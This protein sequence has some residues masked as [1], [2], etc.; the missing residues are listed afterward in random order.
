MKKRDKPMQR[1]QVKA[2]QADDAHRAHKEQ[3]NVWLQ[4]WHCLKL[5]QSLAGL[6]QCKCNPY[7][8]FLLF[9]KQ[10]FLQYLWGEAQTIS[11]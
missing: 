7:L 10:L 4:R 11:K 6:E 1:L 9:A 5:L 2:L 8:Y 3:M